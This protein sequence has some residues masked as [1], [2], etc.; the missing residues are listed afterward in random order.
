MVS[1][2]IAQDDRE[3]EFP[4]SIQEE[5]PALFP[6]EGNEEE[7]DISSKPML[8]GTSSEVDSL[9]DS[10]LVETNDQAV[11]FSSG[12]HGSDVTLI[13]PWS[14]EDSIRDHIDTRDVSSASSS[15]PIIERNNTWTNVEMIETMW[16]SRPNNHQATSKLIESTLRF[17]ENKRTAYLMFLASIVPQQFDLN[18]DKSCGS[19]RGV[20]KRFAL[21][22]IDMPP[23]HTKSDIDV[24]LG[25]LADSDTSKKGFPSV[26]KRHSIPILNPSAEDQVHVHDR[27]AANSFKSQSSSS[28]AS[29]KAHFGPPKRLSLN[30]SQDLE[31]FIQRK[32]VTAEKHQLVI[33]AQVASQNITQKG[34]SIDDGNSPV[35]HSDLLLHH[36]IRD[37]RPFCG[38]DSSH[39]SERSETSTSS[40]KISIVNSKSILNEIQRG[41]HRYS[42]ASPTRGVDRRSLRGASIEETPKK[43]RST[44]FSPLV[45]GRS[46]SAAMSL[47]F[48]Y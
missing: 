24:V 27:A 32:L 17:F 42:Y 4:T 26:F 45:F 20:S 14:P 38:P 11:I 23:D 31:K 44:I 1:E 2:P 10:D 35:M 22:S 34:T 43:L 25:F 33:C 16:P 39:S 48:P 40:K 30:P 15:S 36:L 47:C 29:S 5:D 21:P 46:S 41:K 9:P 6:F 12:F 3:H 18:T 8:A 28:P 13:Q 7:I 19:A 37:G